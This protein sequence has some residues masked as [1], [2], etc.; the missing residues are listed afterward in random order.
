MNNKLFEYCGLFCGEGQLKE[1]E[2]D[3]DGIMEEIKLPSAVFAVSDAH[4]ESIADCST[5]R[6]DISQP[7]SL[8]EEILSN[9]PSKNS[10]GFIIKKLM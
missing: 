6:C 4:P 9:S 10:D 1:L 2:R 7:S 8:K 5:L 3:V